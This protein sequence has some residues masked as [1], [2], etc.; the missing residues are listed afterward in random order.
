[1]IAILLGIAAG[2]REFGIGADF[3]AYLDFY[4]K[5]TGDISVDNSRFELGFVLT[6]I[7]AKFIL[8][9]DYMAFAAML[10][11]ASLLV[12]FWTFGTPPP[13]AGDALLHR[14]LVSCS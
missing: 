14:E 11:T 13:P 4:N 12:K 6:A 8:G 7:F 5:L 2:Y 9:V 10:M 1:M 3:D